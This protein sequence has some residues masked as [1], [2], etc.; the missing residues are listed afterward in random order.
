MAN[1]DTLDRVIEHALFRAG[2]FTQGSLQDS[3]FFNKSEAARLPLHQRRP[4][5]SAPRVAPRLMSE[6]GRPLPAVDWWWARKTPPATLYLQAPISTGKVTI[7]QGRHDHL[8]RQPPLDRGFPRERRPE[9]PGE[10]IGQ[11]AI[12]GAP[13]DITGWRI[14]A[15]D[16]RYLPRIVSSTIVGNLT[17]ATHGQPVARHLGE[18]QR[19]HGVQ[20]GIQPP[21][22][23]SPV[24]QQP[25]LSADPGGST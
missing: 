17:Q 23:L 21:E 16:S 13:I 6:D 19:L 10:L 14:R 20:A 2:E 5:G 8:L 1:F 4:R 24:T 25:T 22:R 7:G 11:T 18:C 12:V 3:D 9:Q 15:G